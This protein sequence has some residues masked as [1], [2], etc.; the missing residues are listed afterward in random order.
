MCSFSTVQGQFALECDLS[1][2]VTN[3]PSIVSRLKKIGKNNSVDVVHE[4]E[5]FDN[6]VTA[7]LHLDSGDDPLYSF[8]NQGIGRYAIQ[9]SPLQNPSLALELTISFWL[10][11]YNHCPLE[12]EMQIDHDVLMFCQGGDYLTFYVKGESY[13]VMIRILVMNTILIS[14]LEVDSLLGDL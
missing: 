11:E 5:E 1:I 10:E 12:A 7:H 13:P 8:A 4:E 6:V 9:T 14:T 3:S 2:E